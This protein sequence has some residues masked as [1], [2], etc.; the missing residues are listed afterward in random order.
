MMPDSRIVAISQDSD[1]S[2]ITSGQ[3][4]DRAAPPSS[5]ADTVAVSD[6]QRGEQ[7]RRHDVSR[8]LGRGVHIDSKV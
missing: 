4:Y 6:A 7:V 1:T 3:E 2:T 5:P 8:I